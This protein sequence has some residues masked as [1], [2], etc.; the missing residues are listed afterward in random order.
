MKISRLSWLIQSQPM[1]FMEF[2]CLIAIIFK[3]H[4]NSIYFLY[5]STKFECAQ[6][7]YFIRLIQRIKDKSK[8]SL[9]W[10]FI[11]VC[12]INRELHGRLEIRP[13]SSIFVVF[14]SF[15]LSISRSLFI[16]SWQ[17]ITYLSILSCFPAL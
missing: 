15:P 7:L 6:G 13:M 10:Y 14:S 1:K 2:I 9:S 5:F 4:I 16:S 3:K 17:R 12:I 11:G 8:K